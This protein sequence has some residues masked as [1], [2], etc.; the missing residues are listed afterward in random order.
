MATVVK[1]DPKAHF[2][3][4]T[5]L[6]YIYIYIH[7]QVNGHVGWDKGVQSATMIMNRPNNLISSRK[8]TSIAISSVYLDVSYKKERSNWNYFVFDKNKKLMASKTFSDCAFHLRLDSCLT[9]LFYRY[10][11]PSRCK[12]H[13]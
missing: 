4:A 6:Y 3:F 2:S 8:L 5:T 7:T 11:C 12:Q 1:S 13:C 9:L 10:D